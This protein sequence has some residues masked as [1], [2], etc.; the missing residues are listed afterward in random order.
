[1]NKY[2]IYFKLETENFKMNSDN[3]SKILNI[4][5]SENMQNINKKRKVI[6]FEI[7]KNS[8][9]MNG[10]VK[11]YISLKDKFWG[12]FGQEFC[13]MHFDL[14]YREINLDVDGDKGYII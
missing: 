1:M 11:M 2:K 9:D 13:E 12:K 14:T 6:T 3:K 8:K 10:I 4:L 7:E 5:S